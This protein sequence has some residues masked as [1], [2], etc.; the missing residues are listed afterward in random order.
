MLLE[1]KIAPEELHSRLRRIESD[2]GRIRTADRYAPRPIDLDLVLYDDIVIEGPDHRLPD[3]DLLTR[4]YLAVTVAEL[5]PARRHPLTG[6]PLATLAARLSSQ[7]MPT[8]RPDVRLLSE[9][10]EESGVR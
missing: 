3:P 10:D 4:A 1:T 8:L 6:E 9:P 5:D 7:G 2:L